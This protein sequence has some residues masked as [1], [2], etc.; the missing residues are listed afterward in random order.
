MTG[1]QTTSLKRPAKRYREQLAPRQRGVGSEAGVN[2]SASWTAVASQTRYCFGMDQAI[3]DKGRLESTQTRREEFF[4]PTRLSCSALLCGLLASAFNL[5]TAVW[6]VLLGPKDSQ[7]PQ[8]PALPPRP[9]DLRPPS[10]ERRRPPR[11]VSA[12]F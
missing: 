10:V 9:C 7:D 2:P 1:S 11:R 6:A 5:R 4:W 12:S 3:Q 8:S